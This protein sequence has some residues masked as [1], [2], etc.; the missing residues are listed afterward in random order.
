MHNQSN[1]QIEE[2]CRAMRFLILCEV[3]SGGAQLAKILAIRWVRWFIL[4]YWY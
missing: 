4:R 2:A 1:M 3:A